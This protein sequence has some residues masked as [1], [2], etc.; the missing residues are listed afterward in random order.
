VADTIR[1]MIVSFEL[2]PGSI[3][4]EAQLTQLLGVSRTPVREAL[5]M[6]SQEFLVQQVPGM[7]SVVAGLDVSDFG[8]V[9]EFQQTLEPFATRLAA[10]RITEAEVAELRAIVAESRT[11]L[12]R[13]DLGAVVRCGLDYHSVILA[14]TTNRY[15]A[16][17]AMRMHR[18]AARFT[19]FAYERGAS[20]GASIDEHERL[21]DALSSHLPDEAERLSREHWAGALQ[22]FRAVV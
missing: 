14:A 13:V 20:P 3:V 4:S 9:A 10:Q 21:V 12:E 17:V 19:R 11:A 15:L 5:L 22:R 2:P 18:C 16:D 8:L 7:G 1:S 6:L